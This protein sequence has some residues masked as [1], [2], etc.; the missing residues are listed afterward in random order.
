MKRTT[1]KTIKDPSLA[2]RVPQ[3]EKAVATLKTQLIGLE[4]AQVNLKRT[5][6]V[7]PF[8]AMVLERSIELGSRITTQNVLARLIGTDAFWIEAAVPVNKLQ[9]IKIPG[10]NGPEASQVNVQLQNGSTAEGKV[11]RLLGDLNSKSQMARILVQVDD[12]LGMDQR[13]GE[14]PLLVNSYVSMVFMGSM[15]E[16]VVVIPR[17]T[18]KEG[19]SVWL[20]ESEKLKIR[21]INPI[22][23]DE[24][25]FYLAQDIKSG[26]LL[27]TSEL[28][29][30]VDGMTVR[31]QIATLAKNEEANPSKKQPGDRIGGK[32]KQP[33][34]A[35]DSQ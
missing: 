21:T 33:K 7:A 26:E 24:E 3:M 35:E 5:M 20:L 8:N 31:T 18:V 30:A 16:N 12:P 32:G 2:L 29:A 17:K 1:G 11:I 22:W 28:T 13:M 34:S 4:Q 10:L 14:M 25:N 15:I 6:I 19:N 9:W 23:E 27:I